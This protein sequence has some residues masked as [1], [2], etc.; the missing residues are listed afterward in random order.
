M[1][2]CGVKLFWKTVAGKRQ[3][4]G[5]RCSADQSLHLVEVGCGFPTFE[6]VPLHRL[7]QTYRQVGLEFQSRIVDGR[8]VRLHRRGD[9]P[10]PD[11]GPTRSESTRPKSPSTLTTIVGSE[12]STRLTDRWR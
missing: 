9:A 5:N 3:H 6:A 1:N 4:D 8:Y 7:P 10:P 2:M 12:T 11:E